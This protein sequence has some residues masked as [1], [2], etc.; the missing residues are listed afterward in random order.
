MDFQIIVDYITGK[1]VIKDEQ[2]RAAVMILTN[3]VCYDFSDEQVRELYDRYHNKELTDVQMTYHI[4]LLYSLLANGA[5]NGIT[6]SSKGKILLLQFYKDHDYYYLDEPLLK[7]DI[8]LIS[9]YFEEQV[10][11]C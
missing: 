7:E 3:G 4:A 5:Q 10:A 8:E 2:E 11:V 9:T 6:P 1:R